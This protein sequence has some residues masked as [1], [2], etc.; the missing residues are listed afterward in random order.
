MPISKKIVW[1]FISIVVIII[2]LGISVF[3][4]QHNNKRMHSVLHSLIEFNDNVYKLRE[5][6]INMVLTEGEN[7][8]YEL[9]RSVERLRSSSEELS[10]SL[11]D[12]VK[13]DL[14]VNSLNADIDNYYKSIYEFIDNSLQYKMLKEDS[15]SY[16][17]KLKQF[18][19]NNNPDKIDIHK[20]LE[21]LVAEFIATGEPKYLSHINK[22]TLSLLKEINVLEL[23]TII[24][25]LN[26]TLETVY[27]N[28]LNV[29]EKR[30]FLNLSSSNFLQIASRLSVKLKE[31]DAR[32]NSILRASVTTIGLICIL[33][34]AFYWVIINRYIRRFL[35]NQSEVMSAIK[36]RELKKDIKPFSNDELGGA[37]THKMWEMASDLYHKDEA[38]RDSE[39]KYRTYINTT[40]V[41]VIVSDDNGKIMEVNPGAVNFLGYSTQE[42]LTF[43]L[44]DVLVGDRKT[45]AKKY[46]M[47][48]NGNTSSSIIR[49]FKTKDDG[50]VYGN[51]SEIKV[52]D[53]RTV[54]FCLDISEQISLEKELK[55]VN[56]NLLEQ[57]NLEVEKNLKQDQIIQQQ[58][59]LAD[60]GMMVSAIAHQWRQLLM[61]LLYVC[62]M[63]WMSLR[64]AI[65][66]WSMSPASKIIR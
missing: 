40:P 28:R 8:I 11:S 61:L 31:R 60:M 54:A 24:Q 48:I 47:S 3:I 27:L 6:Q 62:R 36:S 46:T 51:V 26:L 23:K 56:E 9:Q 17:E 57:V 50:I 22:L 18:I 34:A 43:N 25:R 58:K 53:D 63:L 41:A 42:L 65:W 44:D 1:I 59:K 66:I 12:V 64:M 20:R 19:I 4:F 29:A 35:S 52:S 30:E 39:H 21:A 13:R 32:L 33:L 10:L 38:L 55:R 37:L 49:K 5:I 15:F 16:L 7:S 45:S 14:H 2:S